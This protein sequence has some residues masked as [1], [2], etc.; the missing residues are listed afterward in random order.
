[1]SD[2]LCAALESGMVFLIKE[3]GNNM[4]FNWI[5]WLFVLKNPYSTQKLNIRISGLLSGA[6]AE[7]EPSPSAIPISR[8]EADR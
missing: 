2:R 4:S 7:V 1:M 5:M 8:Q 3:L 6:A